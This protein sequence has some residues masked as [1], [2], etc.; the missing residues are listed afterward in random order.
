MMLSDVCLLH[1]SDLSQEQRGLG[2]PKLAQR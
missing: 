1:T 2:I